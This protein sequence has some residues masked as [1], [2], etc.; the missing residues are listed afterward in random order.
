ML[1][2]GGR[3]LPSVLQESCSKSSGE[4]TLSIKLTFYDTD[5]NFLIVIKGYCHCI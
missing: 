5:V 3:Y 4:D 2:A 1:L